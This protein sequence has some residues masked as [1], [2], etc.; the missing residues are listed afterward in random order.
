VAELGAGV[1][2]IILVDYGRELEVATKLPLV[3]FHHG[4]TA[5]ALAPLVYYRRPGKGPSCTVLIKK[6][7]LLHVDDDRVL[8]NLRTWV[9]NVTGFYAQVGQ[10][11]KPALVSQTAVDEFLSEVA[12]HNDRITGRL[13]T[14]S[15][16]PQVGSQMG[17]A[18]GLSGQVLN[19]EK[20]R[21]TVA[22]H[23]LGRLV[24]ATVRRPEFESA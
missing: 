24:E 5:Q 16:L 3:C 19:N 8:T 2:A 23:F 17:L 21:T 20:S 4:V 10:P 12:L 6:H 22:M 14:L 7:V 13:K 11:L 18:H 15:K 9:D 1:W